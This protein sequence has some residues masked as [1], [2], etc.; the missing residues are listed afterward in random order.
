LLVTLAVLA[1]LF[2]VATP[3]FASYYGE[4]CLKAAM[5]EIAGMVREAKQCALNEK[6]YAISCNPDQGI[7]SLLSGRGADGEWNTAD[8]DVVRSLRLS[9]KGGRLSFGYGRY[10]PIPGYAASVD[11]ISFPNNNTIICNPDLTGNAG[12]VY[13]RSRHGSAMALTIN[14]EDFG[15]TL[16]RWN[17]SEWARL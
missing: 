10:G 6:Y 8:D 16:R 14:S 15:Y 12:T 4:C 3:L 2:S 5:W 13:I 11:G 17:G 9:G 1:I 7:I